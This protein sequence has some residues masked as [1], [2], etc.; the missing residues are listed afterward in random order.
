MGISSNAP[1]QFP[2]LT[3][4]SSN[5]FQIKCSQGPCDLLLPGFQKSLEEQI[6]PRLFN[7]LLP[8]E[9]LGDRKESCCTVAPCRVPSFLSLQPSVCFLPLSTQFLPSKDLFG[10]CQSSRHPYPSVT[11]CQIFL[12]T[13]SSPPSCLSS[14]SSL[15]IS[16]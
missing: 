16:K 15:D 3:L 2:P 13:G 9:L 10:V 1:L 11:W 5:L 14:Q 12:L 6:I 8:Q 7:L 4:L